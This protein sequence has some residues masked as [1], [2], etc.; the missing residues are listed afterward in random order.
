MKREHVTRLVLE[1]VALTGNPAQGKQTEFTIA[2]SSSAIA[3]MKPKDDE[4]EETYVKRFMGDRAAS[5]E[6]PDEKKR[7]AVARSNYRS[8]KGKKSVAKSTEEAMTPEQEKAMNDSIAKAQGEATAAVAKAE[9]L[10]KIVALSASAR[11]HF[12]ALAA[13]KQDVFLALSASLQASEIAKA[14]DANPVEYV[15]KALGQ[16]FRRNDDPKSIAMARKIDEQEDAIA[17]SREREETAILK[18]RAAVAFAGSP[19]NEDEK[20]G[21]LRMLDGGSCADEKIRKSL[22]TK[23][24]TMAK[25]LG[26]AFTSRGFAGEGAPTDGPEAE[27]EKLVAAEVAKGKSRESAVAIVA[28]SEAGR[29]VMRRLRPAMNGAAS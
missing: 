2:K 22:A 9:R 15:S 10:Q 24:E 6:F 25:G 5:G 23:L 19:L 1:R 16:T 12:D 28:K 13:D 17:K 29:A 4:D 7:D 8:H 18:S 21:L 3:K 11:A 20:V 26:E 14:G 27:M